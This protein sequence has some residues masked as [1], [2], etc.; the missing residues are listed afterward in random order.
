MSHIWCF[1]IKLQ[2]HNP[3]FIAFWNPKSLKN[4]FFYSFLNVTLT[5]FGGGKKKAW[6]ESVLIWGYFCLYLSRLVLIF[7]NFAAEI[8]W[9]QGADSFSWRVLH[10]ICK[11]CVLP[12]CSKIWRILNSQRYLAPKVSW[13]EFVKLARENSAFQE[14][15]YPYKSVTVCSIGHQNPGV[16]FL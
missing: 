7:L 16:N 13:L 8:L 5:D 12:Y 6:P 15:V 3:F 9:L 4:N 2:V 11:V 14:C 10:N 1:A